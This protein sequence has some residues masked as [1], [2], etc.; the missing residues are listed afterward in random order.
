MHCIFT[1]WAPQRPRYFPG[2]RRGYGKYHSIRLQEKRGPHTNTA[3]HRYVHTHTHRHTN[4]Q[5]YT[6]SCWSTHACIHAETHSCKETAKTSQ[7]AILMCMDWCIKTFLGVTPHLLNVM[8]CG[9]TTRFTNLAKWV[10]LPFREYYYILGKKHEEK[11]H[12]NHKTVG[13][14]SPDD[15]L[16]LPRWGHKRGFLNGSEVMLTQVTW[17]KQHDE[18]STFRLHPFYIDF[19]FHVVMK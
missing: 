1:S 13:K 10:F 12:S 2:N 6:L 4:C 8:M 7:T 3:F 9:S 11:V 5:C 15:V 19:I 18:C 14:K 16:L 17:Q